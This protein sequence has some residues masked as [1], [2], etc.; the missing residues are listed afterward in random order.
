MLQ[1]Q[2]QS[3]PAGLGADLERALIELLDL[4]DESE[5]DPVWTSAR[6]RVV[7]YVLRPGKRVRAALL[8]AGYT[9][10]SNRPA[11]ESVHRFAAA[12]ELLHTFMLVHDDVAD[13]AELRRGK[14]AL[15]HVLG[16]GRHGESLAVVA[17]DHLFARAI[18]AML[19]SGA[20]HAADAVT[21]LL[22]SCRLTAAGQYLD[23]SLARTPIDEVRPSQILRVAQ[24]KTARYGFVAPLVCGAML[25]G[26]DTSLLRSLERVGRNAGL[27]YQLRDDLLGLF[28]DPSRSGKAGDG[29]FV[30]GKRTFPLI[31]AW[32]RAD[33][34]GRERLARLWALEEKDGDALA[35]ARAEIER[36]GG[37]AATERAISRCTRRARR[38]IATLPAGSSR[39]LLDAIVSR[40]EHRSA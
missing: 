8:V 5:I 26:G 16:S 10:A 3:Q 2:P 40:L 18:E 13:R 39:T 11:T 34:T 12:L 33:E 14:R 30:E 1:P 23:L 25:G 17:G 19:E 31:A 22:A 28:G 15:H 38:A 4:P 36:W 35:L 21:W 27:A 29:D 32:T 7:D 37:R 9:L 24:L 6:E 20:P